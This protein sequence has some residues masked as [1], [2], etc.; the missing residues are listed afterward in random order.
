MKIKSF[1]TLTMALALAFLIACGSGGSGSGGSSSEDDKEI[2][3]LDEKI[4][5]AKKAIFSSYWTGYLPKD[6]GKDRFLEGSSN[7]GSFTL[8]PV[9]QVVTRKL[10]VKRH[11][12]I[13]S[14]LAWNLFTRDV[15]Y[16]VSNVPMGI[17]VNVTKIGDTMINISLVGQ[18]LSHQDANDIDDMTI[19]LLPAILDG[20][21]DL[22]SQKS[23]TIVAKID[24]YD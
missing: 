1:L 5:E 20:S 17:T 24:F 6:A 16:T 7:D 11:Q 12:F 8:S 4:E 23:A 10:G 22:T 19:K 2:K 13:K 18:A 9:I 14:V 21:P 15:H 3:E